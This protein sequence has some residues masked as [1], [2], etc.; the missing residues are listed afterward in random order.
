MLSNALL[1]KRG[2]GGEVEVNGEGGE[3]KV[4]VNGSEAITFRPDQI[5]DS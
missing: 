2:A 5:D 1:F 3:H 4:P